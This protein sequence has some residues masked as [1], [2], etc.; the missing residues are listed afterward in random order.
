MF[1]IENNTVQLFFVKTDLEPVMINLTFNSFIE[2]LYQCGGIS[3]WQNFF[4]GQY[5]NENPLIKD[6]IQG[7]ETCFPIL[8]IDDFLKNNI[9]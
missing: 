2:K 8:D 3:G 9:L 6:L 4:T 7:I 1:T 5:L